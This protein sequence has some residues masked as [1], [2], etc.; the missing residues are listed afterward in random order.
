MSSTKRWALVVRDD[1]TILYG[2]FD[3]LGFIPKF[4]AIAS[5]GRYDNLKEDQAVFSVA[6]PH[7]ESVELEGLFGMKLGE[8]FHTFRASEN[9][10]QKC[11]EL[12]G[13][14]QYVLDLENLHHR[15]D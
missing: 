7:P 9:F 10:P 1:D 4:Q 12:Y 6:I 3:S 15:K 2:M 5:H 14:A 13:K 11:V 8:T